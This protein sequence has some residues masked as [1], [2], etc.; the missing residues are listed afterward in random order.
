MKPFK[1]LKIQSH[2]FKS[3]DAYAYANEQRLETRFRTKIRLKVV[4]RVSL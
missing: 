4:Q 3:H 1:S 2:A